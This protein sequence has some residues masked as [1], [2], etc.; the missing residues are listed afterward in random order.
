MGFTFI[1]GNEKTKEASLEALK[2]GY[3]HID[4]AHGYMNEEGVGE[5]IK[6]SGID[7][8]EIW[9][10]SKFWTSDYADGKTAGTID[11]MLERLGL[12]YLDMLFIH[13]QFEE[14]MDVWKAMEQAVCD[15]KVRLIGLSNFESDR[16]EEVIENAEIKPAVL[17]VECHP[18]YQ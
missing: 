2:A 5:A 10:T 3:R 7:R 17:Q 1:E 12:E 15:G 11:R 18:Y 4:T 13:Q 9:I 14:Y 8:S 16:L 6:E